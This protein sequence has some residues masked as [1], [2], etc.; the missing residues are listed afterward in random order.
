V[1]FH[2]HNN[3]G[4]G[5]ANTI[6]AVEAGADRVDASLA[7]MGAGAGNCPLEVLVALLNRM[8]IEH[9]VDLY[10]LLDAADGIVRPMQERPVQTDGN[11]LMLGYAGD[12]R[13]T[14]GQAARRRRARHFAGAG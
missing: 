6:V 5:A 3:L 2:N 1:G 13:R 8:E 11:A 9:G 12:S 7:G 4:L 14:R 10:P